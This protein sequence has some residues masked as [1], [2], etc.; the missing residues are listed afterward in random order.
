MF[1]PLTSAP[2][3]AEVKAAVALVTVGEPEVVTPSLTMR[4]VASTWT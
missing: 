2:T 4:G 1:R 3:S